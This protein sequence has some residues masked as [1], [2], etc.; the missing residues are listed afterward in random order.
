MGEVGSGKE[1]AARAIHELSGRQGPFVPLNCGAILESLVESELFGTRRGAFSGAR[2]R[3]G[4]VRRAHRGTLLLDE[5]ADMPLISQVSLL[6]VL[7]ERE[8]LAV[9]AAQPETVDVRFIAATHRDLQR[10]VEEGRFREDLLSRLTGMTVTM[11]PLR[12][13]R[14]D[15]GLL[16]KQLIPRVS[17]E[18]GMGA[19]QVRELAP[20]RKAVCALLLHDWPQNVRELEQALRAGLAFARKTGE[21]QLRHLPDAIQRSLDDPVR[22]DEGS[23]AEI[24][25]RNPKALR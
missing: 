24:G 7:Q 11:V 18:V 6:R 4:L 13:R 25:L 22:V 3:H 12:E 14:E 5:V 16:L 20:Q 19:E 1:V 9:G 23:G 2:D 21:L 15:I 10:E 8:V 17:R